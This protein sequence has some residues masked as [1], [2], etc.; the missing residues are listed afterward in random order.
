LFYRHGS[1][2]TDIERGKPLLTV[3]DGGHGLIVECWEFR[4]MSGVALMIIKNEI[5]EFEFSARRCV[6]FPKQKG[7]E[8]VSLH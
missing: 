6:D 2:K 5:V 3:Q 7:A 4:A 8:W 1:P